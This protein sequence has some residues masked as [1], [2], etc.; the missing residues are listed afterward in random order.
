[1]DRETYNKAWDLVME[2][3][4][5]LDEVI[6]VIEMSRVINEHSQKKKKNFRVETIGR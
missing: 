1:M 2:I 6:A 5:K 3:S 4:L